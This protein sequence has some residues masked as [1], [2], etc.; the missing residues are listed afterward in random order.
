MRAVSSR[1]APFVLAVIARRAFMSFCVVAA[2]AGRYF[3]SLREFPYP[4]G[5]RCRST[6]SGMTNG[7]EA[8]RRLTLRS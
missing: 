6:T 7:E 2:T 4:A 3:L 5:H 1:A 8:P